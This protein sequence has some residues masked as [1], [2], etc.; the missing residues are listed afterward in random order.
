MDSS[1]RSFHFGLSE[2]LLIL[3]VVFSGL[4]LAFSSG[5][6]VLNFQRLGFTVLSS[7]QKGVNVVVS[8]IG[9]TVNAVHE[10]SRL[11]DENRELAERLKNYE[12]LQREN[13]DIRKENERLKEQL[14]FSVTFQE[15]N[16]PARIISRNPDSL[17]SA[18]TIDKG[19]FHGIKKNMPVLALQG[20]IVGLVGKVV[21]VGSLT[22]LVMPVYDTK[23]SV[24][25][26]I[27]STRDIGILTGGG[28]ADLPLSMSH[29]KK[30]VLDELRIGDLIVTS[31]EGGNYMADIPIGSISEIRM[32]EYDSSLS[33]DV[34]PVVD[35]ARLETLIVSDRSEPN[36]NLFAGNP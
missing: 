35:F 18:F 11:K 34:M 7:L 16:Y 10:L 6:F 15:R 33:I 4:M 20:G 31:G 3:F 12:L 30:R 19:S 23:C 26:R 27:Q 25:A 21:T 29:I 5:G 2:I 28:E 22:S 13:S 8:G 24:S 1:K 9:G 17:Y 14:G 36:P 32:L